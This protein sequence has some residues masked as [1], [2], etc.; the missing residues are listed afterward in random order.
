MPTGSFDLDYLPV[1]LSSPAL[2]IYCCRFAGGNSYTLLSNVACEKIDY[3]EGPNPPLAQFRYLTGDALLT[4]L[5]WPSQ[6]ETLW[7]TDSYGN[8]VVQPDDRLVVLTMTPAGNPKVLFDGFAQIPR[9][10]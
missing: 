10:I 8:Y 1:S 2:P 3:K 6:F 7:P 9:W 4:N 5:G